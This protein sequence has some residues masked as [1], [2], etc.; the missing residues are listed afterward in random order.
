MDRSFLAQ[1]HGQGTAMET[2]RGCEVSP[3]FEKNTATLSSSRLFSVFTTNQSNTF[4]DRI[5]L[6]I[7]QIS[8][9]NT[10]TK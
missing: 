5:S 8:R 10:K 9:I 3:T 7:I 6:T 2:V 1:Q 4:A